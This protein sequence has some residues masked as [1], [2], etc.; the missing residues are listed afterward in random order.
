MINWIILILLIT[1]GIYDLYLYFTKRRTISQHIHRMFPKWLDIVI[2]C[3]ILGCTWWLGGGERTFV[4]VLC[5]VIL[6]HLFWQ[7]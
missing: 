2:V 4:P 1:T 5:G 7:E 3:G 6:G